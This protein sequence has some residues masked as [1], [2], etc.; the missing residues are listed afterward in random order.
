V[1]AATAEEVGVAEGELLTVVTD[2]GSVTLPV[3]VTAMADRVVWVPTHS[4]GSAV[5]R[6]LGAV[7]GAVVGL[8]RGGAA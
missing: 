8:A 7:V 1:S 5:H 2:R 3:A 6:D 4:P